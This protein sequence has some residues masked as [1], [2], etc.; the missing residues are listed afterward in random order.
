LQA[1]EVISTPKL[2]I[3]LLR[4]LDER[5][6]LYAIGGSFASSAWGQ[7]RQ[8]FDLDIVVS[9]DLSQALALAAEVGDDFLVSAEEVTDALVGTGA[10]RSFQ[11]LHIEE[12]F[13]VDVFILEPPAY[14]DELLAR[15]RSY[16]L[17]DGYEAFFTSPEDIV[18]AKLRW[19]VLGNR[20]SDKQWNDIVHV[21]ET[22]WPALDLNYLQRWCRFFEVMLELDQAISQ[23]VTP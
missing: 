15:R 22:Q 20:V 21:L 8:T 18:I 4:L 11:L 13:K 9:I 23:V 17:G 14:G 3:D 2:V 19:F 1:A 12:A 6:I 7:P 10:F 5:G 16:P